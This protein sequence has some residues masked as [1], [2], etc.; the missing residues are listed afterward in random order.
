ML[1]D[2]DSARHIGVEESELHMALEGLT[3]VICFSRLTAT[4]V[5]AVI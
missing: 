4:I 3:A 5:R 2:G 1:A